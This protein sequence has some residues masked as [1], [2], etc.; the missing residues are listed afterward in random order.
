MGDKKNEP[1]MQNLPIGTEEGRRIRDLF[2][3]KGAREFFIG[4]DYAQLEMGTLPRKEN[5]VRGIIDDFSYMIDDP[6]TEEERAAIG[7]VVEDLKKTVRGQNPMTFSS[8][9][10]RAHRAEGKRRGFAATYGRTAAVSELTDL[11]TLAQ[12]KSSMSLHLDFKEWV[13]RFCDAIGV[14]PQ[15]LTEKGQ[16]ELLRQVHKAHLL[17]LDR[18]IY[19]NSYEKAGERVDPRTVLLKEDGTY[20]IKEKRKWEL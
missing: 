7:K 13:D 1:N 18:L 6:R 17:W 16:M 10:W 3:N 11:S 9:P 14:P 15:M 4:V 19:G 8:T 12:G 20:E 2:E 5:P